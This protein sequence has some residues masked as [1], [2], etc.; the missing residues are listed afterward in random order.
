MSRRVVCLV[1]SSSRSLQGRL[2]DGAGSDG[3]EAAGEFRLCTPNCSVALFSEGSRATSFVGVSISGTV[4]V[5]AIA[6]KT[7]AVL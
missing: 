5:S 6:S 2:D 1:G 7:A 3:G 4:T